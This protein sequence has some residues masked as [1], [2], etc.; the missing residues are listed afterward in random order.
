MALNASL[1]VGE[2]AIC[3]KGM[4]LSNQ[5]AELVLE[6]LLLTRMQGFGMVYFYSYSLLPSN[7]QA[8]IKYDIYD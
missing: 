2:I 3:V 8:I 6:W 5:G 1:S 7:I 4:S